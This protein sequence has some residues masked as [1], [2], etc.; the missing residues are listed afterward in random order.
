MGNRRKNLPTDGI[1]EI[2][3][4][5]ELPVVVHKYN[6]VTG[7]Q[8]ATGPAGKPGRDGATGLPGIPGATG[9]MGPQGVTGPQGATGLPGGGIKPDWNQDD[10]DAADYIKNKPTFKGSGLVDVEND[11]N[12]GY[13]IK[14]KTYVHDQT[15]AS[16]AWLIQHN[17][18]KLPSVSVVDSAGNIVVGDV[19]YLDINSILISF[20]APFCGKAYL[21]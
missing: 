5:I 9:P 16:A 13:T 2:E 7:P 6:G 21:N 11:G 17:L 10:P 4:D 19:R 12:N 1:R 15:Q 8:G 18:G 14:T 3:Y 20:I